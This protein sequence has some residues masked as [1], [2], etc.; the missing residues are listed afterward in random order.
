MMRFFY[1]MQNLIKRKVKLFILLI[2]LTVIS[3]ILGVV[4][5]L[6][7][8]DGILVIDLSNISFIQFLKD[9]IS[10]V[11]LFFRLSFAL[12]IF[13][14][15]IFICNFKPFLLPLAV[16]FYMYLVY[17]QVVIIVSIILIYGFFNSVILIL[18]LIVYTLLVFILF[19]F[20]FAEVN[21]CC[22]SFRYFKES[23]NISSLICLILIF[24]LTFVFCLV[25][26]ILKSFV[27]LL[28]Y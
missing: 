1:G 26:N 9:E 12:T 21:S 16:I 5:G 2:S 4:A 25:L 11:S 17:S 22:G 14:A 23:I 28:I 20:L 19:L 6:N 8:L 24:A 10:F 7:F 13:I 27:I 15:I 3:I 18:F